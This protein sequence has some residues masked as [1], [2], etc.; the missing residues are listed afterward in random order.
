MTGAEP[1]GAGAPIRVLLADDQALLR[2]GLR[3]IVDAT[4][5]LRVVGEAGTGREAVRMAGR[6]DVVLMDVRMPD[7][8]GLTATRMITSDDALSGT[9]VLVLTTFEI[10]E[11]VFE[12][13][14]AGAAGFLG[15]SAEPDEVR[16]AIRT[17]ARGD[18]LLSPVA[19]AT[20]IRRFLAEPERR[21]GAGPVVLSALTEREREVVALAA[22]GLTN[23]EIAGRLVV[24][25]ATA[26][27]HVN[28]AMA[29]LGARSRAQLVVLAYQAGLVGR[30]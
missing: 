29:K 20:L 9:R 4:P 6:A 15:K 18:A 27:T 10:D 19:T 11:Y 3:M 21:D 28:R 14:R 26:K 12:A 17:V 2:A 16:A 1:D 22:T 8:D 23:G 30:A 7:L 25:P 13:L 24:S 5:D